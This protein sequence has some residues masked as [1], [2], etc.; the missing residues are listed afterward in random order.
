MEKSFITSRPD[1]DQYSVGP[2]PGPNCSRML[3]L[4][5]KE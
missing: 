1:V 3:T 4:V 2:D 5:G